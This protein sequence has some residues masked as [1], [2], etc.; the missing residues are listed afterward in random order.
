MNGVAYLFAG[1]G[2]QYVGMGKALA[3][4]YPEEFAAIRPAIDG[5]GID[6]TDICFEGPQ[7]KLTNTEYAQPGIYWV[8]WL[9]KAALESRLPQI[10]SKVAATAGLSLGE[11]TALTSANVWSFEDGLK[12]VH[13]RGKAMQE[14]C[15]ASQGGM[16]A[17]IGL[18]IEKLEELCRDCGVTL[19]NLNCPGQIVVSGPKEAVR[20]LCEK[21]GAAGAKR[22]LPLDVAGA[23]HS[24]LMEP[25]AKTLRS[26][27]TSVAIEAPGVPAMSNVT[28]HP[29][30]TPE[31]IRS[32]LVDQVT[33][34]VRWEDC[35]RHLIGSG[36]Q[37]FV[38][39][40][41]GKALSG[42]MKRIDKSASVVN[43]EDPD[44]LDKAVEF[45][46]NLA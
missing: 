34:P 1:Q 13:A 10:R 32:L 5:L 45:L 40:G 21:A 24:P 22:A 16:A 35:I 4:A 18:D 38:E 23:Y 26:V 36:I 20:E 39:L 29:H 12:V 11:F 8:S 28:G 17:I 27:L 41:P 31:S 44:S 37:T 6:L 9:A 3:E 46:G 14:S 25:A 42:F 33:S 43:V 2:A 7:E 19:A 15:E 30:G